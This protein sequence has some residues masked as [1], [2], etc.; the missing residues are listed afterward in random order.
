MTGHGHA[1]PPLAAAAAARGAFRVLPVRRQYCAAGQNRVYP[2]CLAPLSLQG[3]RR[4]REKR[5][6]QADPRRMMND[7]KS[8]AKA[9]CI[10]VCGNIVCR[11]A[12]TCSKSRFDSLLGDMPLWWD[13][14]P[15]GGEA[16]RC[17][18]AD[19]LGREMVEAAMDWSAP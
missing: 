17:A 2:C 18:F 7:H 5:V 13:F 1:A 19:L 4:R 8:R 3:I 12:G 9:A 10:S 11:R 16:R 6:E 14:L 15:D